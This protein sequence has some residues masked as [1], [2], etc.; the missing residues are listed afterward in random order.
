[1]RERCEAEER[2]KEKGEKEI[3]EMAAVTSV[4]EKDK[5]ANL[6]I[7]TCIVSSFPRF[8]RLSTRRDYIKLESIA[9]KPTC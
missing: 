4:Q 9:Q 5:F 6:Q 2:R 8:A 3:Q 1:M 7:L